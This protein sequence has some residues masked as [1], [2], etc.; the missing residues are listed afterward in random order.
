MSNIFTYGSTGHIKGWNTVFL[1]VSV[2]IHILTTL[3]GCA[4]ISFSKDVLAIIDGEP[5]TRADL[6]YSLEIAHRVEDLSGAKTFDIAHYIHNIIDERLV[7]QEADR[8]GIGDYPEVQK[9]IEDY[10][11]RESVVMLHEEEVLKKVTVKDDEILSRYMEDYET[12]IIDILEAD[13]EDE[14]EKII[15]ELE[16]G[17]QFEE[18]VKRYPSRM[19]HRGEKGYTFARKELGPAV[20]DIIAG[21]LPGDHTD[22]IKDRSAYIIISLVERKPAK[23]EGL[24]AVKNSIEY[25]IRK[26]RAGERESEYLEEL[27]EKA[28]IKINE[29]ILNELNFNEGTEEEKKWVHDARPVVE[30][31]GDILKTGDF[32][33]MLSPATMKRKERILNVWIERKIVDHEALSRQFQ[34]KS[35]LKDKLNRYRNELLQDEFTSRVIAPKVRF[36]ADEVRE[37]YASHR[38][39]FLKPYKVRLQQITLKT[40]E[41]AEDA[42]NSL[43]SGASFAWLVKKKSTDEYASRGGALGWK[44]KDELEEPVRKIIETL[45]PGDVSEVIEAGSGFRI[46][47]L[48]ER[49]GE[50]FMDFENVQ[51]AVQKRVFKKKYQ[52]IY[53]DYIN[54]LKKEADIKI[55][56]SA[57]KEYEDMFSK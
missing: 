15:D 25:D 43:R 42:V 17:A 8:M 49:G 3:S 36:S 56:G 7:I 30:I 18:L 38:R 41:E 20:R 19:R 54:I 6:E 12:F 40:R 26:Q 48:Q 52:E 5:V 55:N 57:I 45:D 13:T 10:L 16:G 27:R 2:F 4:S 29:E 53:S 24:A 32:A 50:E 11:V 22:V 14:A 47:R 37:Y 21:M 23:Q 34:L 46:F 44:T 35:P 9:K 39:E 28:D 51:S 1:Y 33:A 31:N